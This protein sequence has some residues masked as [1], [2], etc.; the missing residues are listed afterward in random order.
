MKKPLIILLIGMFFMP[1]KSYAQKDSII[2]KI[3][4]LNF[5]YYQSINKNPQNS[6]NFAKKAF[7]YYKE[8]Q[9]LELKF[10]IAANY[11]TALF[12]NEYY[13]EALSV[14]DKIEV[15]SVNRK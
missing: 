13:N 6:L 11:T 2:N 1:L 7:S 10:K 3:N 15:L 9:S 4:I 12:V 8:V 5:N 14:L